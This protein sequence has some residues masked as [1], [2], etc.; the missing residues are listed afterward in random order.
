MAR[1]AVGTACAQDVC[2]RETLCSAVG[3]KR[4]AQASRAILDRLYLC[5]VFN[6]DAKALQTF[7]QNGLGSP[8]RQAA[9]KFILA[10]NTTEFR[11]HDFLQTWAEQ[12]DLPDVHSGVKKRLDQASPV[13]DLE[14]CRLQCGPAGLVM[15]LESA[16]Y[17]ARPD[18][19]TK[20]FTGREQ[21]GWAASHD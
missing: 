19:M 6:L 14:H 5:A 16:L 21:S 12:L 17:H 7:A 8:L 4:H 18:A 1:Y 3:L 2:R 10:P 11:G 15:R 20:K 9:L 13:D